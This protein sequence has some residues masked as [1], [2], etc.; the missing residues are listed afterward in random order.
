[1]LNSSGDFISM[2]DLAASYGIKEDDMYSF[3]HAI[4][5]LESN[6]VP[7][8]IQGGDINK[9]GRGKYQWEIGK[10]QGGWT[11]INRAMLSLPKELTPQKLALE[12]EK[13]SY[14][15]FDA[16][17]NPARIGDIDATI[18]NEEEQDYIQA[19]NILEQNSDMF[20]QW[21][22]TKDKGV[23]IDWWLDHHWAGDTSK[24]QTKKNY[25]ISKLKGMPDNAS[26][27][28]QVNIGNRFY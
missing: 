15:G 23:L 16:K 1:M 12:W 11:R 3:L 4:G 18:F 2:G 25:A 20:K 17:G 22:K 7:D 10:S 13:N 6:N 5:S 28:E 19:V 27:F 8:A 9:P 21:A 24:R 26:M 14:R